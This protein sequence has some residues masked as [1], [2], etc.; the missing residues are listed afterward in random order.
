[1]K[2]AVLACDGEKRLREKQAMFLGH[3]STKGY[4]RSVLKGNYYKRVRVEGEEETAI[5]FL[6]PQIDAQAQ[7]SIEK[8]LRFGKYDSYI[9][10]G[11][12]QPR[13]YRMGKR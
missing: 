5:F 3:I 12:E 2:Y 4:L 11:K 13:H 7:R 9:W 1:M 8:I 6:S 10:K